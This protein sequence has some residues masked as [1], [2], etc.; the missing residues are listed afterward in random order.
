[1]IAEEAYGLNEKG[2]MTSLLDAEDRIF[3]GRTDPWTAR[4]PLALE[5]KSPVV[6]IESDSFG[7]E[8]GGLLGLCLV[9]I[10]VRDRAL[11]YTVRGE[12]DGNNS[13]LFSAGFSPSRN[14]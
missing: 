4:H 8:R 11:R 1:M 13:P 6:G 12:D 2:V 10:P 9:G 7:H 5:S 14:E 3:H